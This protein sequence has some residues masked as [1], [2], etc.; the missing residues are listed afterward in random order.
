[1]PFLKFRTAIVRT[2]HEIAE[3]EI[4]R[5]ALEETLML[6][7]TIVRRI[8]LPIFLGLSLLCAANSGA[9]NPQPLVQENPTRVSDHVYAIM[10]FP[11]IA[12]VVGNRATL[13]VDTGLGPRNGATAARVAKTLSTGQSLQRLYLTTTH[14]HPEHAAGEPGFPSDT[15]L[16]RPT[17]QQEEMEK[18]GA[19]MISRFSKMSA[20]NA[21][22]LA[23][24]RLRPPD[25]VFENEATVDLGGVTAR[26]LWFGAGHTKGD[27]LVFVEPDGTLI[28]GDI[29]QNRVVPGISDDGGTPQSWLA[30]LDKIELLKPRYVMPDHSNVG[31]GSLVANERA[32]ISDLRARALTLK[33]QGVSAEDAGKRLTD[34]F[35]TKYPDW[36]NLNPIANFVQRIYASE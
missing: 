27:E 15:I 11:N 24:V 5:Y 17:V 34:E 26:L 18:H 12:I 1:M 20:Q 19:E 16:I 29:V 31:D 23:D 9:Q 35:K 21:Q 32:F 30:I 13:V 2:H 4:A 33:S 36:P 7:Q 22:L 28:S 14:F 3:A 25:I 8:S 10:G 6:Q